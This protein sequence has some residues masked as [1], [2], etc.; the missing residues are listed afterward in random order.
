MIDL[1]KKQKEQD[2]LAAENTVITERLAAL[3]KVMEEKQVNWC[4]FT[5]SDPHGSEY[6]N[7][8][9]ESRCFFSGFTGSNGDLLVGVSEALLWTDGRYFV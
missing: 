9:Y 5:T 3:R 1:E 6:I 7:A 4:L 8:C 2:S